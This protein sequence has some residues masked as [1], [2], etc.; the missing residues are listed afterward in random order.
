M[1]VISSL[2]NIEPQTQVNKF[3]CLLDH[4][5][6]INNYQNA[7]PRNPACCH[8]NKTIELV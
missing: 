7:T 5:G 4:A 6:T 1:L 2:K 8:G 3:I